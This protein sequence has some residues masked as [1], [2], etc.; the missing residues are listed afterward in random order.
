MIFSISDL[1]IRRPILATVCSLIIFLLG[2]GAAFT[3]PI[4]QYPNITPPQV[5]VSSVYIGASAEVVEAT[6]TNV[7]EQE[8]NGIQG[9]RY[10]TSTS[11]DDGVSTITLTF[12]PDRDQDLAAVDVQNRVATVTSRLP[13]PVQQTGVRVRKQ[14]SGFLFAIGL[15]S[16]KNDKGEPIYDDVFLSNYADLYLVDP[17]RRVNGVSNVQIFGERRFAI[18]TWLDPNK[19]AARRITTQD[20]IR[21]IQEQ[22]LQI[23]VGQI[24]QQPAPPDL[25]YQLT[26]TAKGRLV[27]PEQFQEI[28]VR[29]TPTGELIRI[30]DIGRVEL[31]AENYATVLRFNG[32]RAV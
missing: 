31:G 4:G 13:A 7:L 17:I 26:V 32:V 16:D 2:L 20:V 8:L 10:I 28:I 12:E 15:Y 29:A 14:T 21:A 24:G 18:R 3:L 22:N 25:E 23:G 27:E 11:T 5:V 19:M 30:K 6:V 1:F 9:L